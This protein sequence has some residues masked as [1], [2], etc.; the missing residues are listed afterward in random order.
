MSEE[1]DKIR[2]FLI[3]NQVQPEDY[4]RQMIKN[5]ELQIPNEDE[6]FQQISD[7]KLDKHTMT[8]TH[9]SLTEEMLQDAKNKM[10]ESQFSKVTPE[11]EFNRNYMCTRPD[12]EIC[13]KCGKK[14]WD[15]TY[16]KDRIVIKC[17]YCKLVKI[18]GRKDVSRVKE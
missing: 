1:E 15:I 8:S 11:E 4:L 6:L 5:S 17:P 3:K 13:D 10:M 14:T 2:M 9:E 16:Q 12:P 7:F 18:S